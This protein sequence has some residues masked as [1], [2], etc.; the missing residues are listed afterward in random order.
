[1]ALD[2]RRTIMLVAV[3]APRRAPALFCFSCSEFRPDDNWNCPGPDADPVEWLKN[4]NKRKDL[5]EKGDRVLACTLAYDRDN[6]DIYLQ[7][8]TY[9]FASLAD[10]TMMNITSL[11]PLPDMKSHNVGPWTSLPMSHA[12]SW[13]REI[14]T[15]VASTPPNNLVMVLTSPTCSGSLNSSRTTSTILRESKSANLFNVL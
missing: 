13:K 14:S 12:S 5:E 15:N 10:L 3:I 8:S 11:M 9:V 4:S 6:D 7:V 1:M 2:L